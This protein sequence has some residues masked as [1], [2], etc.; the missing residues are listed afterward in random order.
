MVT[1]ALVNTNEQA[2]A[3]GYGSEDGANQARK[4]FLNSAGTYKDTS[5]DPP[6]GDG[7]CAAYKIAYHAKWFALSLQYD[8]SSGVCQ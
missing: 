4:D 7:Y 5:C 3:Q 8:C 2:Q 6:N 1:G